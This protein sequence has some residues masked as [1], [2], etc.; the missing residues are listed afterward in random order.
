MK[1]VTLHVLR[2]PKITHIADLVTG[3]T[4]VMREDSMICNARNTWICVSVA[5]QSSI[6]L[7]SEWSKTI[8]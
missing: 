1:Q 3:N 6:S 7:C 2:M 5:A 4:V 8:F